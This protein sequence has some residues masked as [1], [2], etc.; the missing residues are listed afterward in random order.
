MGEGGWLGIRWRSRKSGEMCLLLYWEH[1]VNGIDIKDYLV[2]WF[3]IIV[4]PTN[5]G[6]SIVM[7]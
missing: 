5:N 3:S 6:W 1:K 7:D 4:I 2:S